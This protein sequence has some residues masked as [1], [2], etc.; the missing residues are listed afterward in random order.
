VR[1]FSTARFIAPVDGGGSAYAK[2]SLK[3]RA[4]PT[5]IEL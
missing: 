5:P 3:G 1:L 2:S 4:R